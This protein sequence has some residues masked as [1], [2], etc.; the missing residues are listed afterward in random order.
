MGQIL[1]R[2]FGHSG[3]ASL[4]HT[5][6]FKIQ[7]IRTWFSG[8]RCYLLTPVQIIYSYP[9]LVL[10]SSFTLT[11]LSLVFVI[12][13]SS[14]HLPEKQKHIMFLQTYILTWSLL[15]WATV[16]VGSGI[17][18]VYFVTAWN[19]SVLLACAIGCVENMLG[20]QGSYDNH[21]VHYAPLPQTDDEEHPRAEVDAETTETT[22]LIR[23]ILRT[24]EESGAIGWWIL[25]FLLAVSVPV[26]LV[27]H[28]AILFIS[29]TA[30]TL[31]DGSSAVTGKCAK[32]FRTVELIPIS[33]C[34]RLCPGLHNG[35]ARHSIH[36]QNPLGRRIAVHHR[37]R[38]LDGV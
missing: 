1:G 3:L 36:L 34:G 14:N 12:T 25:Q 38:L 30:Q 27:S 21:H 7:S 16:A 2:S 19:V 13:P 17:G 24:K 11:Y 32:L 23:P 31:A 5:G 26:T 20:A 33:L 37:L 4:A 18:G 29:A 15:I 6:V 10:V 22:P 28:I 8:A 9:T 35:V